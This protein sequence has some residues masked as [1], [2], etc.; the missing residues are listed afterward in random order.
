[1]LHN[2][3]VR[4]TDDEK[5]NAKSTGVHVYLNIDDVECI[6][7]SGYLADVYDVVM[8]SR[9]T[10]LMHQVDVDTLIAIDRKRNAAALM[11]PADDEKVPFYLF[12]QQSY[13][14]NLQA[15]MREA[16]MHGL[17]I[18]ADG[19]KDGKAC[20]ELIDYAMAAIDHATAQNKIR[21]RNEW[22][23]K[24]H[25]PLMRDFIEVHFAPEHI[26]MFELGQAHMELLNKKDKYETAVRAKG[27]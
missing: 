14:H 27:D 11:P 26:L 25:T 16:S 3:V 9:T 6:K 19:I 21:M 5:G 24:A 2:C 18:L 1:M 7:P 13:G 12:L 22:S 4:L 20:A 8:K 23:C 10:Y 17:S 15:T